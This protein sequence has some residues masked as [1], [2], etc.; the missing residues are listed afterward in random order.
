MTSAT[1]FAVLFVVAVALAGC[2]N[3]P[4]APALFTTETFSGSVAAL[5]RSSHTF[6]TGQSSATVIRITSFN[7]S[8]VTMGL[9]LGT[10]IGS[11][12]GDI[13]TVTVGQAAVV[14]GD[15]FQ[16][17]LDAATYCVMIFDIGNVGESNTV[18]YSLTV[19]HR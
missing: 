1:R 9:A 8:T 11:P 18:S 3:S 5:A 7:P 16:V 15:T 4:A 14:Q 10:P 2:D 13:C 6:A 12:T 19:Q 17:P